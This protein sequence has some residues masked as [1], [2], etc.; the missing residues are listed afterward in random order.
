M[1]KSVII[2]VLAS[3]F[4]ACGV[5][6][7]DAKKCGEG[8]GR[9]SLTGQG[10]VKVM[11]DRVL[12]NY[13]VSALKPTPDEARTEVE[14]TVTAFSNAVKE[15]KLDQHS[16]V[17]DDITIVPR[18]EYKESKQILL[19]YEAARNVQIKLKDFA[20]ISK[21]TDMAMASGINQIAGFVYQVS[22]PDK[23]KNEAA[24]KAIASVK[25]QANMLAKGFELNLES[26]CSITY[27]AYGGVTPVYRNAMV[28]SAA[29]ADA[30]ASNGVEATYSPEPV[31]VRASVSVEYAFKD[32]K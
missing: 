2:P 8:M 16:F 14:K 13:R 22:D 17:A 19:G 9:M 20:L 30:A 3:V 7:A 15:L 11:P 27:N 24:Q 25:E 18:Y 12:L 21:V 5:A 23:Y 26:P 1:K 10:E 32:K 29:R 6:H 31:E 4:L 28:M